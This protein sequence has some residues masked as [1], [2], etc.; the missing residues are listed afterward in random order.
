MVFYFAVGAGGLFLGMLLM[1]L[2]C[3]RRQSDSDHG[4]LER[5]WYYMEDATMDWKEV[6]KALCK[7]LAEEPPSKPVGVIKKGGKNATNRKDAKAVPARGKAKR[8]G[9]KVEPTRQ[10]ARN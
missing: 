8:G 9:G 10:A 5:K 6:R 7:G 3:S 1:A 2:L 4:E